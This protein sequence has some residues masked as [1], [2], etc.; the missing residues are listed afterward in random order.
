MV[1][2][3]LSG[4]PMK[5]HSL[6]GLVLLALVISNSVATAGGERI[7][8]RG[9][10]MGGTCVATARGLDAVGIN[11]ANLALP[12]DGTVTFSIAPLGVH[13]GSNF[14]SY[15]LYTDY[16]TGMATDSGRVGRY[17]TD[18]DKQ[19]ILGSF[20]GGV[21]RIFG[22]VDARVVSL[23]VKLGELGIVALTATEHVAARANIP[24]QYVEFLFYG[25][26]PGSVY[27]FGQTKA[28]A[29]WSR[30]YALSFGTRLPDVGF[31]K[32]LSG[33]IAVKLVHGFAYFEVERFNNRLVTSA[34][35]ILDGTIDVLTRSSRIDMLKDSHEGGFTPFPAPAGSGI[36][37]DIGVSGEVNDYLRVGASVTD[38]GSLNWTANIEENTAR[39]A[40]HM[41]DPLRQSQRDSIQDAVKGSTHPGESF[42]TSLPTTIRLGV[43]LELHKIRFLRPVILGE[44]TLACD[45][46]QGLYDVPGST[47]VGRI[48]L[49]L[50]F[51]PWGFLPIRTG[52]SFGGVDRS[53]FALGL[54]FH[55]GVFDLDFASDNLEWI[56][57][58]KNFSSG[59]A[60]VGMRFRI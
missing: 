20:P 53:N 50:E 31:L 54:G 39:A 24:S 34:D 19:Q 5:K 48:S 14:L 29:I 38:I 35:G 10:G 22:D 6:A 45:Y 44:M 2:I 36:G 16:F 58:Q 25:N 18:A 55:L 41:D 57:S 11:P 8:V 7:N 33:G 15:G 13:V 52:V 32:S 40:I 21:G 47:N 23:S 51:K 27:D 3:F 17:L 60:S 37:F 28:T 12:D 42:S 59:S 1:T 30:E 46:N 43:A 56:F 9:V 49:G 4:E 26:I